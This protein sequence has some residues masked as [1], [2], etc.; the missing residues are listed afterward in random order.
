ME[1]ALS[2]VALQG[3]EQKAKV[4]ATLPVLLST[5]SVQGIQTAQKGKRVEGSR[6]VLIFDHDGTLTHTHGYEEHFAED[7]QRDFAGLGD[8]L[9]ER[10]R[11]HM[12]TVASD[13]ERTISI[14][15]G[16]PPSGRAGADPLLATQVAAKD[17]LLSKPEVVAEV[18]VKYPEQVDDNAAITAYLTSLH[19]R[20][21]GAAAS[22][23]PG[24][25]G[26][27]RRFMEDSRAVYVVTNSGTDEIKQALASWEDA[28]V[29]SWLADRVKGGAMKFSVDADQTGSTVQIPGLQREA[30]CGR[31]HYRGILESIMEDEGVPP[32][33]VAVIGDILE[34]DLLLPLH[35]GMTAVLVGEHTLECERDYV[36]AQENGIVLDSIH[37]LIDESTR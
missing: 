27:F 33:G 20:H 16:Q 23:R 28:E 25:E 3:E 14:P 22:Y 2:A 11:Q 6:Q 37:R 21:K 32:A 4:E 5:G 7:M 17:L 29:G 31:A 34:F 15:A 36:T 26:V 1:V 13:P 9:V 8:G 10:L 30:C 12:A 24:V 35:L 18:R 19:H